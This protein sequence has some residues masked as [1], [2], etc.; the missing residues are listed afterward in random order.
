MTDVKLNIVNAY[1]LNPNSVYIIEVDRSKMTSR[2]T[3]ELSVALT[4]M[5]VKHTV[6]TSTGGAISIK[7]VKDN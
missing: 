2:E 5:G 1:E 3:H 6:V 7:K 4:S